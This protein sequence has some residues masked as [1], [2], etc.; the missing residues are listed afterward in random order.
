MI[1][2]KQSSYLVWLNV[3][4]ASNS[5]T[6]DKQ[7][8]LAAT[9]P[10]LP[11]PGSGNL[12]SPAAAWTKG[13]FPARSTSGWVLLPSV[14]PTTCWTH[15]FWN[16][17]RSLSILH[18]FKLVSNIRMGCLPQAVTVLQSWAHPVAEHLR[19]HTQGALTPAA[20]LPMAAAAFC[21]TCNKNRIWED[22]VTLDLAKLAH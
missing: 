12:E 20:C 18:S 14:F 19:L 4:L 21:T 5:G 16:L 3:H 8:C 15:S 2:N 11:N 13:N 7:C 10:W 9:Q 6:L 22:T 1:R 17:E